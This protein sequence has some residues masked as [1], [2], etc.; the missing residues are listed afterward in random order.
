MT[1]PKAFRYRL[2]R[3]EG[4]SAPGKSPAAEGSFGA[5]TEDGF[6]PALFPPVGA[7][8]EAAA[9]P[10]PPGGAAASA[11]PAPASA[12]PVPVEAELA[13]IRAE[14]LTGR[15]LRLARR[16]GKKHGIDAESDFEIVRQLRRKGIDPF[17]RS[18][19]LDSGAV[20]ESEA[21]SGGRSVVPVPD[22]DTLPQTSRPGALAPLTEGERAREIM[23]VQ[24]DIARRRRR[25]VALLVARLAFFVFLPT[26]IAGIY[27]YKIATPMYATDSAFVIQKADSVDAGGSGMGGLLSGTQYATSQDAITVQSY[28][29]SRDAMLRLDHDEDFRKVFSAPDIDALQRLPAES[30]DEAAFKLYSRIVK[31]GYDTNEGIVRMQ[32]SAP[33]PQ[34]SKQFSEALISY[35]EEQVDK[36][37]ARMRADQMKGA[38]DSYDD[39]EKKVGDAQEQV[40]ALQQQL[41]VLDPVSE[42]SVVMS[43]IGTLQ[44][45]LAQKQ[46]ELGQLLDNPQPNQARVIGARGDIARLQQMIADQRAEQTKDRNGT[47]SL[48]EI[49]G[50][51]Q[52]AQADLATR[53]TLLASAATQLESSRI[54]ANKQVRYLE[55]GVRPIPPDR[56]TYPRAFEDTV[57]AFLVFSGIY[58]MLSLTASILREQVSG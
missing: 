21:G 22:K 20:A 13:A 25:K 19:L 43:Q 36:L 11:S 27:F 33:T 14:G 38:R 16:I 57:L 58:L 30:S 50:R 35:A 18:D 42:N 55:L 17:D 4:R 8:P 28:L 44:S 40:L 53:Q 23:R 1:T 48:A 6:D 37:T 29:Q 5:P 56:P 3:G 9:D 41:G 7:K 49:T 10:Q 51:L 34:L 54:E 31:V 46:L 26:L 32:V 47:Q 39:A 45:Q 24:R 15:Q 12:D 2:R 52:L